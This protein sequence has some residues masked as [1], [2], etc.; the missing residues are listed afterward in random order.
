MRAS[1]IDFANV[2]EIYTALKTL[3]SYDFGGNPNNVTV[4]QVGKFTVKL[5]FEYSKTSDMAYEVKRLN[6]FFLD[7]GFKSFTLELEDE[8]TV[9]SIKTLFKTIKPKI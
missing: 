5:R 6:S 4:T 1:D 3:E 9:Y 2:R 8:D 7:K